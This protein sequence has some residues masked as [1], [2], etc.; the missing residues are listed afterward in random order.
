MQLRAHLI[1]SGWVQGVAFRYYTRDIARRLGLTGWVRNL[2]DGSVE[3][4]F[5]GE[6]AKVEEMLRW[7]HEGPPAARV[8]QVQV[9]RSQ[10]NGEYSRF[11]I[12]F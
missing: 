7:C 5:E 4:V 9:E 12:T 6:E 2:R 3:A 8:N 11:E 1:I 10:A